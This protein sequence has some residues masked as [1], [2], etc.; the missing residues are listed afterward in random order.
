MAESVRTLYR[1]GYNHHT[2][3]QYKPKVNLILHSTAHNCSVQWQYGNSVK[4]SANVGAIAREFSCVVN[5]AGKLLGTSM[6]EK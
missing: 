2:P 4:D 1:V 6:T 3:I 5:M